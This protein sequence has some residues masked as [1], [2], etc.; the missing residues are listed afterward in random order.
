MALV[1]MHVYTT[2]PGTS[3]ALVIVSTP[4]LSVAL[5]GSGEGVVVNVT[6]GAGLPV[7]AQLKEIVPPTMTALFM[8]PVPPV[9]AGA[10]ARSDEN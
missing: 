9:N 8:L 4:L 10:S 6:V 3:V 2:G 5:W 7:A 1:A